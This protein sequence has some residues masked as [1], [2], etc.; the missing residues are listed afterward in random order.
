MQDKLKPRSQDSRADLTDSQ[1]RRPADG[2]Q[3]QQGIA[4]EVLQQVEGEEE[5]RQAKAAAKKAKKQRQKAK[6]QQAQGLT[7]PAS[8]LDSSAPQSFDAQ[9]MQLK[10]SMDNMEAQDSGSQ[11]LQ[12]AAQ[13]RDPERQSIANDAMLDL[14]RCP[15]TKVSCVGCMHLHEHHCNGS[16]KMCLPTELIVQKDT[17]FKPLQPVLV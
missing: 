12:T 6:R 16:H 14:L 13:S 1:A 8:E 7:P 5:E 2:D 17:L 11:S 3:Q 9:L 15:I 4:G 10:S